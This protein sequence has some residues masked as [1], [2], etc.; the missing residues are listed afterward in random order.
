[1]R[2]HEAIA[3][4]AQFELLVED[5]RTPIAVARLFELKSGGIAF[6]GMGSG[7]SPGCE[8]HV[9]RGTVSET[10]PPWVLT[11]A[12]ELEPYT[13][14]R[15]VDGEEPDISVEAALAY[16]RAWRDIEPDELVPPPEM[17]G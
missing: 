10:G 2:L 4:G 16:L 1:M 9:T 14:I 12:T 15:V 5:V 7:F 6:I 17:L 3:Q 13:I 11:P 8:A